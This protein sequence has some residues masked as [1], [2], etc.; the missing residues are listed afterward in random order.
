MASM[1]KGALELNVKSV[2]DIYTEMHNVFWLNEKEKLSF[3]VITRIFKLG[4]SRIPVF[5][6]R[7]RD[8]YCIGLIYAKDLILV[9][10]D[11]NIPITKVLKTFD[12][13][14]APIDVWKEDNLQDVLQTFI[15]TYRHLAF[16]KEK[17]S[18]D[19]EHVQYIG[20][21]TLEDVIEE[22]LKTD[23]V[24]E[25]DKVDKSRSNRLNQAI[26]SSSLINQRKISREEQ[27]HTHTHRKRSS[28]NPYKRGMIPVPV[29]MRTADPNAFMSSPNIMKQPFMSHAGEEPSHTYTNRELVHPE[30]D[31]IKS[32]NK[33]DDDSKYDDTHTHL[34][35]R[36]RNYTDNNDNENDDN[37]K[38]HHH[39]SQS[40]ARIRTIPEIKSYLEHFIPKLSFST[41]ILCL[42]IKPL[43][44]CLNVFFIIY[45]FYGTIFA[46]HLTTQLGFDGHPWR[47]QAM[48]I[49]ICIEFGGLMMLFICA[50]AEYWKGNYAFTIDC[51]LWTGS[52][53]I[54][55]LFYKFQPL[56]LIEYL[57]M[58]MNRC[59]VKENHTEN[60]IKKWKQLRDDLKYEMKCKHGIN[61]GYEHAGNNREAMKQCL[62]QLEILIH[63][64]E[65]NSSDLNNINI[66]KELKQEEVSINS[67]HSL[68]TSWHQRQGADLHQNGAHDALDSDTITKYNQ[69]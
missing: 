32:I 25:Y 11:D 3:D 63:L 2:A 1:L 20:I 56:L 36:I 53:S 38:Q 67:V 7:D 19:D 57:S 47:K 48:Y 50:M 40:T 30:M 15:S 13:H 29:K 54:F 5:R 60:E 16:V 14:P 31:A 62:S 39:K 8:M 27:A 65:N 35:E 10:P 9:D 52:W 37:E 55:Q 4:H 66:I 12:H 44:I 28:F 26:H 49:I 51:I 34:T 46:N 22:I 33:G 24:D 41:T 58:I 45:M 59:Y 23:L 42:F 61:I 43:L 18:D 17:V 68:S 6:V 64:H 69:K 21:I